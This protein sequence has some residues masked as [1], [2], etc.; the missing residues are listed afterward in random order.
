MASP[1]LSRV[2]PG[3]DDLLACSFTRLCRR[4]T[5]D[6]NLNFATSRAQQGISTTPIFK[7]PKIFMVPVKDEHPRSNGDV[8]QTWWPWQVCTN[9]I[10]VRAKGWCEKW[11]VAMRL[12]PTH[13]YVLKPGQKSELDAPYGW[14]TDMKDSFMDKDLGYY[15]V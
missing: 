10:A 13:S 9:C 6:Y 7:H 15:G 14:F 1:S 4:D 12:P 5:T 8:E 3:P 11:H 2:D